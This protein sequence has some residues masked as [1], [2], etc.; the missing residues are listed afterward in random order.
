M[1]QESPWLV[2]VRA[3]NLHSA[4][5]DTTGLDLSVNNK[6]FPEVDISY[7]CSPNVAAELI[8]ACRPH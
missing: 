1:A 6:S 4:N 8:L 3:V 5:D 2:R 7:F